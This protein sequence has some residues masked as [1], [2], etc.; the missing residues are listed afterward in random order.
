MTAYLLQHLTHSCQSLWRHFG[1]KIRIWV[2]VVWYCIS[3]TLGKEGRKLWLIKLWN[4][5]WVAFILPWSSKWPF[6]G[7]LQ[8]I[9]DT[10]MCREFLFLDTY[11]QVHS[12]LKTDQICLANGRF[13]VVGHPH[14]K[15]ACSWVSLASQ[16]S[17]LNNRTTGQLLSGPSPASLLK[18]A[19]WTAIRK[20]DQEEG[21]EHAREWVVQG[22]GCWPVLSEKEAFP[23]ALSSIHFSQWLG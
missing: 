12:H 17:T 9:L 20:T 16:H 18:L 19:P 11:E 7:C 6:F 4:E 1:R 13:G 23:L 3:P 5:L 2:Q 21:R 8:G 22:D 14:A 10:Y 15:R